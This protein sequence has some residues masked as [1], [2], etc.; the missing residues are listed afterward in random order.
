METGPRPQ[1]LH[2][3][4]A[5]RCQGLAGLGTVCPGGRLEAEAEGAGGEQKGPLGDSVL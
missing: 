4:S 5:H 2:S 3:P 1:E